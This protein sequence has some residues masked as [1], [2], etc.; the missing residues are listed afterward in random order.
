VLPLVGVAPLAGLAAVIGSIAYIAESGWWAKFVTDERLHE[1]NDAGLFNAFTQVVNAMDGY[2]SAKAKAVAAQAAKADPAVEDKEEISL[3]QLVQSDEQK[4]DLAYPIAAVASA[5]TLEKTLMA[6]LRLHLHH[7]RYAI[8]RMQHRNAQIDTSLLA[9]NALQGFGGS[10]SPVPIGYDGSNL[11]L[12]VMSSSDDIIGFLATM[13]EML[14]KT[15]AGEKPESMILPTPGIT[16]ESRLG[17]C[18]TVEPYLAESRDVEIDKKKAENILLRRE[19]ER[20][21]A[22]LDA[23]EPL[24]DDP[25]AA[26]ALRVEWVGSEPR[27]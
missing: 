22:R 17:C 13:R 5:I 2:S 3:L 11:L 19:S 7:Y 16:V 15:Y 10:I 9:G 20:L 21:K 18:E 6:H 26:P 14:R 12:R 23:E 25:R 4:L 8:F 1:P 24:L 27:E